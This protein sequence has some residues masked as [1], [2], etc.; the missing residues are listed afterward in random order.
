MVVLPFAITKELAQKEIKKF[1]GKRKTFAHPKFK[2]E[3]TTNNIMG[4][5][6]PYMLV[7]VNAHTN[8]VGEGEHQTRKYDRG[9]G[10]RRQTYYDADLYHVEREFDLVIQ[11]LS[12]EASSERLNKASSTKTN[13][14]INAS[15]PLTLKIV[16]S[17]MPI[18]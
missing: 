2:S 13:N 9:S 5:Y 10:D 11:G 7:D 15:C 18:I 16:S 8:F 3:F 14:V 1:V 12:V 4:V 17:I 6:F